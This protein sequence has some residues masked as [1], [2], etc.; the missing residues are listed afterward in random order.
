MIRSTAFISIGR[1]FLDPKKEIFLAGRGTRWGLILL[2]RIWRRI[3]KRKRPRSFMHRL[4]YLSQDKV[5][6]EWRVVMIS[7]FRN[8]SWFRGRV[9]HP[10]TLKLRSWQ[11]AWSRRVEIKPN[12]ISYANLQPPSINFM[13]EWVWKK[14]RTNLC[15]SFNKREN[16][17][18]SGFFTSSVATQAW[19]TRI[20]LSG[21]EEAKMRDARSASHRQPTEKNA[22]A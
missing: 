10:P 5:H 7:Y 22:L 6:F 17:W 14:L 11:G 3:Q 9:K 8:I 13:A 1:G 2:P 4:S 20:E 19:C 15:S 21:F 12:T 18:R 16:H